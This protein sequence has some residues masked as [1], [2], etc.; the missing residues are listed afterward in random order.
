MRTSFILAIV[1]APCLA[2]DTPKKSKPAVVAVPAKPAEPSLTPRLAPPL[3]DSELG[4]RD[5]LFL[6][7]AI[8]QGKMQR[9]L[10]TQTSR[11]S[12]PA[13]RGFGAELVKALAAQSAVLNT[14]AEMRKLRIPEGQSES[15]RRITAKVTGLEGIRL[16][17][18][19]LDEFRATDRRA[20][21]IYELGITSADP[22]IRT[23]CEQ[24]L[25]QIREH[26]IIVDAMAG[27]APKRPTPEASVV[28]ESAPPAIGTAA[29]EK[30]L[31]PLPT[32]PAR[33]G[34]RTGVKPPGSSAPNP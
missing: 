7:T 23:F 2:A 12:N 1:A 4:G 15:E 22:T 31:P 9:F 24:T 5:L 34:F 16:E 18:A 27:I 28:G 33:P 17:K 13:L 19:L 21:A 3:I 30:A 11:T 26:L 14:V 25:P 32:P 10:A 6:A 8:E 29:P 20:L